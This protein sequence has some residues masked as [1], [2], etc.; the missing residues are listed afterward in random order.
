[1]KEDRAEVYFDTLRP[2]YPEYINK[3]ELEALQD[4]V[5]II[6][7]G[8]RDI[9]RYLLR[10]HNCKNI[11]ELGAAVGYSA[12]VMSEQISRDAHVTTVEKVPARI[13][14]ARE[15]FAKY[16]R[17]NK[18]TLL[19]GDV[20]DV[21]DTL[22]EEGREYDFIFLDAAKAQYLGFL[23]NILKLLKT[24]GLLVSDNVLHEGDVLESRYFIRRRDRTIHER[25]REYLKVITNHPQL[26]TICL[27]EGDGTTISVKGE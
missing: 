1:M 19:E 10:T 27:T 7:R 3:L 2:K 5:P 16:D 14:K 18:I 15:N 6:R 26:E 9:L 8:T 4:E 22:V 11:L 24:G 23:P 25:M 20:Y 17:N 12:L 13:K 21:L